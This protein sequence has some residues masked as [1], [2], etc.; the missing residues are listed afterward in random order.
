MEDQL[1]ER[2]YATEE[3]RKAQ[4][5]KNVK[6]FYNTLIKDNETAISMAESILFENVWKG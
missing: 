2:Q 5:N 1:W 3:I 6:P 4:T